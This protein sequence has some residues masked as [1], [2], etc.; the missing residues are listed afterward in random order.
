MEIDVDLDQLGPV[1]DED[2]R[3]NEET[4]LDETE[5][6]DEEVLFEVFEK[7]EL[8]NKEDE[9]D[10]MEFLGT[11]IDQIDSEVDQDQDQSK[12]PFKRTESKIN[13]VT[14]ENAPWYP[15]PNKE[16]SGNTAFVVEKNERS[17]ELINL[18][19]Q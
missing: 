2:E 9:L 13:D 18:P 10:W 7:E 8:D 17:H 3:G 1:V 19:C 6:E 4:E 16:V 14:P 15:F 11:A 5:A 12:Y